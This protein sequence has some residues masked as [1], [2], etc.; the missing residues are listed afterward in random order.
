MSTYWHKPAYLPTDYD[1]VT[2][3]LLP[4]AMPPGIYCGDEA[5]MKALIKGASVKGIP[6]GIDFRGDLP[7]GV[8]MA[9]HAV[10]IATP[11]QAE[12]LRAMPNQH[13]TEYLAEQQAAFD[14]AAGRVNDI[15]KAMIQREH[16]AVQAVKGELVS[17][18]GHVDFSFVDHQKAALEASVRRMVRGPMKART[19]ATWTSTAMLRRRPPPAASAGPEPFARLGDDV[20]VSDFDWR[21]RLMAWP[22]SWLFHDTARDRPL[23][24]VRKS[25]VGDDPSKEVLVAL[26]LA[27]TAGERAGRDAGVTEGRAELAGDIR[28]LIGAAAA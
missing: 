28:A 6:A 25:D 2:H 8:T 15:I 5:D 21:N 24:I 11:E 19:T 16:E 7:F 17:P 13:P 26:Y 4:G 14:A 3:E 20:V 10:Y 12:F 22:G 23:F 27:F 18:D 9:G 1:P